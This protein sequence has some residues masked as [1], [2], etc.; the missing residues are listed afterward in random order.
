MKGNAD[1]FIL[2]RL[3]QVNSLRRTYAC[4]STA[5]DAFVRVDYINVAGG[6]RLYRTL[7]DTCSACNARVRNFVSHNQFYEIIRPQ[8]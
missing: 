7:A 2:G 3:V 8:K 1:C 5:F 6:Y 4:A